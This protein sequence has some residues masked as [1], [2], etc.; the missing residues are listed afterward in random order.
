MT[1]VLSTLLYCILAYNR[2]VTRPRRARE[3]RGG[4]GSCPVNLRIGL[5][6]FHFPSGYCFL[7]L[8]TS[9]SYFRLSRSSGFY[10]LIPLSGG[11]WYEATQASV[12]RRL[13]SVSRY[14]SYFVMDMVRHPGCRVLHPGTRQGQPKIRPELPP[15]YFTLYTPCACGT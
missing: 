8:G 4:F 13:S 2:T 10:P 5:M 7:S 1:P 6:G 9:F 15:P 11:F 12:V 14:K 3:S